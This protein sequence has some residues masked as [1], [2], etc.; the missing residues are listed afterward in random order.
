MYVRH[1]CTQTPSGHPPAACQGPSF[2][3][4][5]QSAMAEPPHV[6]PHD[7]QLHKWLDNAPDAVAT[8][9]CRVTVSTAT[10]GATVYLGGVFCALHPPV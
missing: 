5:P 3:L 6:A 4:T 7:G 8:P 9:A 2:P 10:S 1:C